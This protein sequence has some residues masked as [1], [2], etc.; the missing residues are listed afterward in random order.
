MGLKENISHVKKE[1]GAEEQFLESVIK[2]ESLYK[3]FKT[4]LIS[5]G[6][7]VLVGALAFVGNDY[8]QAKKLKESN[9]LYLSLLKSPDSIKEGELQASNSKLYELYKFQTAV[10]DNSIESLT[11]LKES[12]NDTRL[13]NLITYQLD[14]LS[15]KDLDAYAQDE[16][17][18]LKELAIIENAFVALEKGEVAK[19]KETLVFIP[20]ISA[21]YQVA[22]SLQHYMK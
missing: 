20:S 16:D 9:T 18:L 14:S 7:V 13:K 19:A 10:K 17:S 2:V 12:I 15:G 21:F 22:Q 6:V 3:K 8:I 11:K 5:L 4:P 1:L